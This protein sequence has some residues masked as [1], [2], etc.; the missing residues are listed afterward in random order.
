MA[1]MPDNPLTHDQ[2][3]IDRSPP[4]GVF[5]FARSYFKAASYLQ[6]ALDKGKAHLPFEMPVYYL[7]SHALELTLKAFLQTKGLTV[8]ELRSRGL[9]H[10]FQALWDESIARGLKMRGETQAAVAET[11]ELLDPFSVGFDFRYLKVGAMR[12][13]SLEAVRQAVKCLMDFVQ[14][15]CAPLTTH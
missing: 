7:Y 1:M 3:E 4:I 2:D 10:K 14:P 6:D 11:I 12:R 9:G 13:P 5:N 15:L 8:D